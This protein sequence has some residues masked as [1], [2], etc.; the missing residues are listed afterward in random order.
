MRKPHACGANLWTV[1][2]I[3][4]DIRVRC[5]QCGRSVML[6]RERFERAVRRRLEGETSDQP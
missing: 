5:E 3:G 2:R 6:T 4:A 1:L